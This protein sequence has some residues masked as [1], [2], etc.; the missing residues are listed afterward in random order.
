MEGMS[1]LLLNWPDHVRNILSRAVGDILGCSNLE[2]IKYDQISVIVTPVQKFNYVA[3]VAMVA[4]PIIAGFFG[5]VGGA[6][7]GVLDGVELDMR[8]VPFA[9]PRRMLIIVFIIY[10]YW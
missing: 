2:I 6:V 10:Y 3:V 4:L 5:W 7:W 9:I 1:A 8:T